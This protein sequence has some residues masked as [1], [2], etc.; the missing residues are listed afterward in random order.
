VELAENIAE[1]IARLN[2]RCPRY[3]DLV[4]LA[5]TPGLNVDRDLVRRLA[6]LKAWVDLNGLR[7]EH[8][9]PAHRPTPRL[10]DLGQALS[11][12]YRWLA[13]L[14]PDERSIAEGR[15]QDRPLV[16]RL[17]REL[18]GARMA[19]IAWDQNS[20]P[21]EDQHHTCGRRNA[22]SSTDER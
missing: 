9:R 6:V 17:L 3:L 16:L 14:T 1:K 12:L 7:S 8:A 22:G 19:K 13:D 4:W 15:P 5:S 21:P 18:P 20:H 2:R 10:A 11:R